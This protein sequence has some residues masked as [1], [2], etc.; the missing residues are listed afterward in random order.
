MQADPLEVEVIAGTRSRKFRAAT[1]GALL[2]IV[3]NAFGEGIVEDGRRITLTA[4][5]G[6]LEAGIYHWFPKAG[7]MS[8]AERNLFVYPELEVGIGVYDGAS[9]CGLQ[10]LE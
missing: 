1:A 9:V 3:Q 10:T 2:P 6:N 5:Y 8:E 4:E 7:E